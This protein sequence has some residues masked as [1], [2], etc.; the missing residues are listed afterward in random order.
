V[1]KE[2]ELHDSQFLC[3]TMTEYFWVNTIMSPLL[4]FLKGLALLTLLCLQNDGH[5][6]N[7]KKKYRIEVGFLVAAAIY[8]LTDKK[9][10]ETTPQELNTPGTG[11]NP[12]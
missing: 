10:N 5:L 12:K 1:I 2:I 11:K 7:T 4:K 6:H 3:G 9:H 8:R